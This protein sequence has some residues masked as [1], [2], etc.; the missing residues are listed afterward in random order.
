MG[1]A[2]C[3]D[4]I[5]TRY[6]NTISE[7]RDMVRIDLC[8]SGSDDEIH[9]QYDKLK[10]YSL[11]LDYVLSGELGNKYACFRWQLS[12]GGPS[13]EF[14]FPFNDHVFTYENDLGMYYFDYNATDKMGRKACQ[15][16][17]RDWGDCAHVNVVDEEHAL[18]MQEVLNTYGRMGVCFD[19]FRKRD[20][21]PARKEPF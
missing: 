21:I 5:C 16:W 9:E 4:L 10:N 6:A 18:L 15:Y 13:D 17:F 8:R 11:S 2:K 19:E 20:G 7:I 14:M 12:W 1:D 3:A